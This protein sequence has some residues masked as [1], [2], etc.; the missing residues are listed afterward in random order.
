M[1]A[2]ERES[3]WLRLSI[4]IGLA[5]ASSGAAL[6][7][8]AQAALH[9][10]GTVVLSGMNPGA[11]AAVL[12][13]EGSH[14]Y[15]S[16][17]INNSIYV[18]GR[19]SVSGDLVP[20]QVVSKADGVGDN[21]TR[22]ALSPDGRHLYI[23]STPLTANG[24]TTPR[25]SIFERDTATGLLTF[26]SWV[27]AQSYPQRIT[28]SADGSFVYATTF[29]SGFRAWSRDTL[30][31]ALTPVTVPDFGFTSTLALTADGLTGYLVGGA[32]AVGHQVGRVDYASRDTST[33]SLTVDGGFKAI[34]GLIEAAGHAALSA[35]DT[36]LYVSGSGYL[37]VFRR[38][39]QLVS[40]E[41]ELEGKNGVSG[42]TEPADLVVGADHLYVSAHDETVPDNGGVA[43]FERDPASGAV[44]YVERLRGFPAASGMALSSD[45]RHLYLA[46][47]ATST[48][49]IF[50]EEGVCPPLPRSDCRSPTS[51]RLTLRR[52]TAA[53][54]AI[55]FNWNNADTSFPLSA[56]PWGG[57]TYSLCLYQDQGGTPS[58][59]A[60]A[61]APQG[62]FTARRGWKR[63][64]DGTTASAYIYRDRFST[65]DGVKSAK[66]ERQRVRLRAGGENVVVPAIPLAAPFTAQVL[67]N[68]GDCWMA[69]FT[70]ADVR[71]SDPTAGR[72]VARLP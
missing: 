6:P 57:S 70:A 20:L 12:S 3:S 21:P 4:A 62:R 23:G 29:F 7:R 68:P 60:A 10:I 50:A 38:A 61:D 45:G 17:I 39:P 52:G 2:R 8:R 14:L 35:G 34:F 46:V 11:F 33:G 47:L 24:T 48:V 13:P 58:L 37:S 59:I 31:G 28:I 19:D 54:N 25:V 26:V 49:E 71:V 53:Q 72:F 42:L 16:G 67:T 66:L 27:D 55:R 69:T 9:Q 5:V 30:S 44:H 40:Q 15:V 18:F 65:P 51:A 43:A 41:Y 64:F 63:S 36:H 1:S 56:D 32:D 22:P